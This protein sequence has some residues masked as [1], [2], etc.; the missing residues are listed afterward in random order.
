MRPHA[1][2]RAAR[3]FLDRF[4]GV[5]AYAVKA[6]DSSVITAALVEEG[7]R[8]F[9][10]ASLAEAER[11]ARVPGATLYLMNPIKSRETIRRAYFNL[12]IRHFS[13]DSHDEL[14]KILQVTG[15]APDLALYVRLAC[16]NEHSL[17]PLEGKFGVGRAEA[18]ALLM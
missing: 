10:V 11:M 13:L 12:G 18:P 3:W 14:D 17:I 15:N 5:V 4:P 16:S 9:D 7:I 6:N 8:H 1:A 2:R